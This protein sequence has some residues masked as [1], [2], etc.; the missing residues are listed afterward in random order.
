MSNPAVSWHLRDLPFVAR[1]VIA[2]FLISVGFGY[3]SALVQVHVQD[4]SNGTP[5]PSPERLIK[6]FHGEDGVS[7]IE[8][9]VHADESL[10]FGAGGTMRPAFTYKS[11]GWDAAPEAVARQLAETE[12]VDFD[13]LDAVE[14]ARRIE[15][16]K[17]VLRKQ[18]EGEANA[19]ARW[20]H[21]GL[22][23][24]A[25]EDD[26]YPLPV[27]LREHPVTEKYLE[28]SD[29]GAVAVKIRT[30]VAGR[31]VKCH[32][33]TNRTAAGDVPLDDY[34]KLKA[35][36]Q[37]K[38]GVGAISIHKLAQSTHVHMLGF[39]MLYLLTGFLFAMTSRA[40][41]LRFIIAPAPLLFQMADISCW[42]LAR[43]DAPYGPM[44]AVA[45]AYTGGLVGL[46]LWLQIVLTLFNLFGKV[47][48]FV[49]FLLMIAVL[50]G[51]WQMYDWKLRGFMA[52][53]AKAGAVGHE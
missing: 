12:K 7:R 36:A 24:K 1:L 8:A 3:F 44:F 11:G 4:S 41:F 32:T 35:Y 20:I 21:D 6:K 5:L 26:H 29:K 2:V 30:L 25:Y 22:D 53:E 38:T 18:R 34:W 10:P 42:W 37:T 39:S 51:S 43:I 33:A 49:I 31:C 15:A 45:V 13:A 17:P 52:D 16:A 14:Q 40:G 19:L 50:L 28:R 9:L 47:G 48:K 23:K 27:D 46:F